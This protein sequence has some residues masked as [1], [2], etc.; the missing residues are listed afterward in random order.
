MAPRTSTLAIASALLH[1]L[2]LA[3]Q[4]PTP[5]AIQSLPT[6]TCTLADGCTEQLTNVVFAW[7]YHWMHTVDG[8]DSCTTSSGDLNSTL[9]GTSEDCFNNCE[10]APGD[11]EGLGISTD[12]N[13]ITLYQYRN[14]DGKIENK[15]PN[16]MLLD[17]AGENYVNVQLLGQEFSFDVDISLLPCGENGAL[18]LSEMDFTGGR[19]EYNPAGAS[20]GFG[21]CSAQCSVGPYFNGEVNTE[22]LGACC[23]E[24]DLWEANAMATVYTPHPCAVEGIYGCT[25]DEC[26]DDGVCAKAGC[27]W[28]TYQQGDKTFYGPG[29]V[30]DTSHTFTVT[31]Q[32]ITD[33]GTPS[34]TLTEIRRSYTQDGVVYSNPASSSNSEL[35]SI[36]ADFC[37]ATNDF[38]GL[39]A[40]GKALGRGMVL[41]FSL[42]QD[43]GG[44]MNWLDSDTAG[45]CSATEGD[46][47]VIKVENP[48]AAI[49]YSNIRWGEIGSTSSAAGAV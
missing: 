44:F 5:D 39:A 32:F 22:G 3:Q 21:G 9:C 42:W 49:T 24:M 12:G 41:I 7:P 45:P 16:V 33:D 37:S 1:T 14:N 13:A 20:Y 17:P 4:A 30:I 43:A 31:T 48:D 46:P 29:L 36:T 35:N 2:T 23:H 19:S 18:F 25:G 15:S 38:G 8:Y 40:H 6:Y 11:Y 27:G 34:G 26:G 28:N 10:L 47:A